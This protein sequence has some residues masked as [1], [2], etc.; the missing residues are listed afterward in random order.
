MSRTH[1]LLTP[2]R[3]RSTPMRRTAFIAGAL[4]LITFLTSVP[5]LALYRPVQDHADFVLGAGSAAGVLAGASLEVLLAVSCVGTAAV[6]FPVARRQSE[7][8]AL[9]FLASRL[10]EG[11]LVLVGVASLLS[12]ISLRTDAGTADPA[13]LVTASQVLVALYNRVFLLSQSLM[14][15]FSALCLGWVMYRSGL[16]P[17]PIPL[18]GLLGAPLLLASDA[19]ILWGTYGP[20]SPLAV[21]AA[22]PVAL[23]ELAFGVWLLARGFTQ[24]PRIGAP[25]A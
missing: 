9:G 6:L 18:L 10:V 5:T 23:W 8:A 25:A 11:G 19:A 7:T 24:A 1:P 13:S 20:Q 12:I 3:P 17:R 15:A 4:Y 2:T 22:L 21:L 16:V 14:P